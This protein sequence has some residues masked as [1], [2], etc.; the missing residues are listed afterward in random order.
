MIFLFILHHH[1]RKWINEKNSQSRS[2][3]F[4]WESHFYVLYIRVRKQ[5]I[6]RNFINNSTFPNL[7]DLIC[8][9]D[10]AL[11]FDISW[12]PYDHFLVSINFVAPTTMSILVPVPHTSMTYLYQGVQLYAY[13]GHPEKLLQDFRKMSLSD[14]LI[15]LQK[16]LSF[17]HFFGR[18][19]ETY[20][21]RPLCSSLIRVKQ[22]TCGSLFS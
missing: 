17:S 12:G 22:E 21:S 10:N 4:V 6:K 7:L 2:V 20:S 8:W 14:K 18:M 13:L 15:K 1:G 16:K 11:S 3:L 9:R 19:G 5:P